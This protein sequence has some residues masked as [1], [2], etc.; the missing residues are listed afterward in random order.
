MLTANDIRQVAIHCSTMAHRHCAWP[1]PQGVTA[2]QMNLYFTSAM[3]ILDRNAMQE[4]FRRFAD[5]RSRSSKGS[6][7][8]DPTYD[9]GGDATRHYARSEIIDRRPRRARGPGAAG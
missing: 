9:T 1:R 2:A 5:R 8:V 6:D 7:R 4:Q 3:M